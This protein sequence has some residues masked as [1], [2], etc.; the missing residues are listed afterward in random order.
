MTTLSKRQQD[1]CDYVVM[2]WGSKEIA[3][4]LGISKRTVES[5]REIIYRKLQVRNVVELVRKVLSSGDHP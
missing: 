1:V 4:Q 3:R 2:G 5:H